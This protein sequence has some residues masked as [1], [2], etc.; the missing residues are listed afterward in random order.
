VVA[1]ESYALHS[2]SVG[3]ENGLEGFVLAPGRGAVAVIGLSRRAAS[4]R[5]QVMA[6]GQQPVAGAPVVCYPLD[7]PNRARLGGFR[8]LRANSEGEYRIAGLPEGEYLLLAVPFENFDPEPQLEEWK[9]RGA[10]IRVTGGREAA[11]NL[12]LLE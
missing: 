11:H 10:V 7:S 12:R 5:G 6:A 9:S 8:S 4:V 2:V 1:P 3:E